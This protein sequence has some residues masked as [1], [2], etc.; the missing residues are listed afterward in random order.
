MDESRILTLLER[1][2]CERIRKRGDEISCSCPFGENHKR[3]DRRP[4]FGVR[5]NADDSSPYNCFSCGERGVLEGLAIKWGHTDL[6]PDYKP[7]KVKRKSW[8]YTGR[9]RRFANSDEK[10][11]FF[12][13]ERLYPFVGTLSGYLKSRGVTIDT[14]RVW[15]LG[16]D[17]RYDRATFTVR[18]YKGRL[19]MIIGR[20]I[21]GTGKRAKYS[22]YIFDLVNKVMLPFKP[23]GR[24]DEE[25]V[26][27]TRRFF[28]FGEHVYWDDRDSDKNRG[29]DLIVVEGPTDVLALYQHGYRAVGILGSYPS[30]HQAKKLVELTPKDGRVVVMADGDEAGNRMTKGVA[31]EIGERV[32]VYD[33]V[34]DPGYDPGDAPIDMIREAL[35]G[36]RIIR[37]TG[38]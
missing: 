38:K 13:D 16:I 30:E 28:L 6:V 15:E 19:A 2:G 4:S 11:V 27:P 33:A 31:K 7:K 17:R 5:V 34:L 9:R 22:N 8:H 35:A 25:F 24:P 18:D 12:K 29:G 36:A 23:K 3:G 37:L 21:S 10:P 20:D 1:L 26:G 32:P 14:A